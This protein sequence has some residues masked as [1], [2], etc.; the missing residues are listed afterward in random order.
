[1]DGDGAPL[2][3]APPA[4]APP[5]PLRS[6]R[7]STR[8]RPLLLLPA[9]AFLLIFFAYPVASIVAT[10]FM[11]PAQDPLTA[12]VR[13][14]GAPSFPGIVAFTLVQATL[15]TVLT[16]LVGLPGAFLM[17]RFE[18]PGK[19]LVRA[20]TLV[21]FILPTVVVASA[22]V[23]LLGPRSPLNA[24]AVSLFG[25]DG[26]PLRLD[27][28]LWAIVA[29][30][31]FYNHAV[32]VRIVGGLWSQLDERVED[33]ARVLGAGRWT[34]FRTVT[35]PLLRPA[36]A[37]ASSIVFLFSLTSF[38]VILLLGDPRTVTLE[39]EIYRRTAALLDLAGAAVRR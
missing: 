22:F 21:P 10:G 25:L 38:G 24:A 11:D 17:A 19:R 5:S 12:A 1:V 31:V 36:I 34:T 16:L 13:V 7:R 27:G 15:S 29:A 28:S 4:A 14:L 26:P 23:A 6:D 32:V 2:S 8:R 33:A 30:H 39:V 20:L 9:L 3:D 18:F 37:S 35:L